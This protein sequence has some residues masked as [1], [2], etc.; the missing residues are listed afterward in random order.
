M[1]ITVGPKSLSLYSLRSGEGNWEQREENWERWSRQGT[2]TWLMCYT[3]EKSESSF[4]IV[5][6]IEHLIILET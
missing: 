1:E 6:I 3:H 4:E 5:L 2:I